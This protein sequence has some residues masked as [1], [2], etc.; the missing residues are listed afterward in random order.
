MKTLKYIVVLLPLLAAVL[1]TRAGNDPVA[2]NACRN[3]MLQISEAY[4]REYNS[5]DGYQVTM[6]TRTFENGDTDAAVL[7]QLWREGDR[8]MMSN[9]YMTV[10]KDD[11]T[12]AIVLNEAKT[13]FLKDAEAAVVATSGDPSN[14]AAQLEML[15]G[16]ASEVECERGSVAIRFS[17]DKLAELRGLTKVNI[18][19][20]PKKGSLKSTDY[21]YVG[22]NGG[23]IRQLTTYSNYT[24]NTEGAGFSGSAL[25][26]VVDGTQILQSFPGYT[27][28]DLRTSK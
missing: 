6:T 27:I 15:L 20:D 18:G 3:A 21:E 26:Q 14:P 9:D 23:N 12:A 5:A 8:F 28:T 2:D 1:P 10:Y 22:P 13:I 11:V 19:F 24:T 17:S 4:E 16:L 25:S 7:T